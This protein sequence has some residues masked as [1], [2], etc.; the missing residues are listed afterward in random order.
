MK[1]ILLTLCLAVLPSYA[2]VYGVET[3]SSA[4][5]FKLPGHDGKSYDLVSH[6]GKFVVLEW[7]NDDCPYVGKHYNS[8]NMQD[9][10]KLFVGKGVVWWSVISSAPGEEGYVTAKEAGKLIRDRKSN[11]TVILLDPD[12]KVG[13]MYSAQ[14]TPHMYVI[15]PKGVL[16]YQGA[17][18]DKPSVRAATIKTASP[19]F[20]NALDAAMLGKPVASGTTKPYGC[21]VKY[22]N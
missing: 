12:G 3:G 10:Q 4:P 18:D 16:V 5:V 19:L 14:T 6:R 22:V 1:A 11:P 9:L 20:K 8:R 7:Y 21:S 13:R 2:D 17:I 15:D